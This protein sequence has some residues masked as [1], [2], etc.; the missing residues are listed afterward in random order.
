MTDFF[1]ESQS[2]YFISVYKSMYGNVHKYVCGRCRLL[3]VW[4]CFP[5]R[6]L[7]PKPYTCEASALPA[8]S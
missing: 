3:F 1:S 8:S 5:G 2:F 4:F 6:G 7:N